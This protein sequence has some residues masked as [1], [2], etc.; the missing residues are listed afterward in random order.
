MGRGVKVA[1]RTLDPY[2]LVRIRAPQPFI[3]FGK[4]GVRQKLVDLEFTERAL[5]HL[6]RCCNARSCIGGV[7]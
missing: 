6:I 4:I 1:Q 3:W 2:I 7:G 5:Q